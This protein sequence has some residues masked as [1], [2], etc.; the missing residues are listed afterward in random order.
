MYFGQYPIQVQAPEGRKGPQNR[1]GSH[2]A[3]QRGTA[4]GRIGRKGG[5]LRPSRSNNTQSMNVMCFQSLEH[6]QGLALTEQ[7]FYEGA[8]SQGPRGKI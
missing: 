2:N 7:A 5:G 4:H 8:E 3:G 6:G 1:N